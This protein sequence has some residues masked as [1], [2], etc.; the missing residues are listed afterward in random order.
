M[1]HRWGKHAAFPNGFSSS[2]GPGGYRVDI[3]GPVLPVLMEAQGV[4]QTAATTGP[5]RDRPPFRR[6]AGR[7]RSRSRRAARGGLPR[8]GAA[9]LIAPWSADTARAEPPRQ[10]VGIDAVDAAKR[11]C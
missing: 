4:L 7:P 5:G 2:S 6:L 10:R 9:L 3:I 1:R 11:R 8:V